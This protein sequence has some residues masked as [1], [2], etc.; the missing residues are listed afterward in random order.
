MC[1]FV[2]GPKMKTMC[3]Q[4]LVT[5]LT[6]AIFVMRGTKANCRSYDTF[7][8]YGTPAGRY[9]ATEIAALPFKLTLQQC[10][11]LCLQSANCAAF[12]HNTADDTCIFLPNPCPLAKEVPGMK[13]FVFTEMPVHQCS[14]WIPYTRGDAP[15]GRMIPIETDVQMV[16][17]I[18]YKG[19]FIIGYEYRPQPYQ[20]CFAYSTVDDVI[21][22]S[23]PSYPCE[24]LRIADGSTAFWIPYTARDRL[25]AR[26]VIGGHMA[27]G[28]VAYV[29][30]FDIFEDSSTLWIS[31]YY[32][33]GAV[34]AVSAYYR[35]RIST[36]MMM[37]VVL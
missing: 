1:L 10:K 16:S 28:E 11:Y 35:F 31:G 37:L 36:T 13:Y 29:V 19:N 34:Y 27:S 17:R 32:T 8:T 5:G 22:I 20:N 7:A 2:T 6:F 23:S 24:R 4:F 33:E 14:Q 15:D 9:C 18:Q 3:I 25:P 21:V 26:A 30:K 12:N